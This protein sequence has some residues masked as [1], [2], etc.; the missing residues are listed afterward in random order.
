MLDLAQRHTHLLRPWSLA[1]VVVRHELVQRRV[2]QA[3]GH[4]Q[5]VHGAEQA[6]EVLRCIGSSL[7]SALRR[8]A[9]SSARIISRTAWNA[10][11][12][13]EHVLGAAQADA[14]GAES[15]RATTASSGVSA[16]AR[17][18]RRL[19]GRPGHQAPKSPLSSASF[20]GDFSVKHLA[21]GA[22]QR[23]PVTLSAR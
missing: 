20:G 5:A 17:T 16:L 1:G 4:R 21:G 13:K 6:F 19:C 3:D 12:L 11:A 8:P 9:S 2:E 14:G 23:D 18:S 7:A 15:R 22:V 10:F